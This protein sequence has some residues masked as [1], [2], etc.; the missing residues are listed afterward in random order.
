AKHPESDPRILELAMSSG[1]YAKLLRDASQR[2]DLWD[3]PLGLDMP[4]VLARALDLDI[5][6][7]E[8]SDNVITDVTHV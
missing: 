3:T 1:S 4:Y 7:L 6:I 2:A 5:R 8:N